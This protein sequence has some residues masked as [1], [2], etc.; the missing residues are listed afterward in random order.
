KIIRT[1]IEKKVKAELLKLME[2]DAEKYETFFK[3]FGTQLKYGIVNGYGVNKDLL[4]DLIM[5]YSSKEQKLVPVSGYV[6]NMP[7]E[8][9]YIYYACGESIGILDKLPQAEQ[10][11][12]RG[13]EIL[14]LTDS[15]DEFVVKTLGKFEEREFRSVNDD[16]LGLESE[17]EKKDSEQQETESRE[18]LDFIKESLDGKVAAVK[19]SRK[20]KSHPACLATQGGVSLEMERYFASLQ[21]EGPEGVKAERVLELNAAHPVFESLK[22]SFDRD[23]DRASR[24]AQLLYDQALIFA[25]LQIEDPAKFSELVCE[26]MAAS[27][28]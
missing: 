2:S 23:R 14:Y 27:G 15:V 18:L 28:D 4:S 26:L 6:K 8:Q 22:K 1:N 25:G 10:V 13:Y 16:D 3:S 20:L 5:F 12:E 21:G 7:E 11:R 9:K 17:D 19:L 24:F